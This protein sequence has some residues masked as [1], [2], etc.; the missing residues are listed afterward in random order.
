MKIIRFVLCLFALSAMS[1]QMFAQEGAAKVAGAWKLAV[2]TPHG[3]MPGKL[4][5]KQEGG[6][7][8]GTCDIEH[9]GS[10]PLQGTL[11]GKKISFT[12]EM[13]GGRKITF[14]GAVNGE[15]MGGSTDPE[16]GN[17]SATREAEI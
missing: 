2:D 7:I 9:M 8:S 1:A 10:L 13:Q 6:N 15:K 11:E 14:M 4:T 16:G 5:L 12:I 17:W 3:P